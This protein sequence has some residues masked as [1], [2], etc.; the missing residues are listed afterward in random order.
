VTGKR[1]SR[2]SLG[3]KD[4]RYM[5]SLNE[6][7]KVRKIFIS[8]RVPIVKSH[9]RREGKEKENNEGM[10]REISETEGRI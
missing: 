8:I 4:E 1:T 3:F 5:R 6:K 7:R 2:R 9:I 10:A